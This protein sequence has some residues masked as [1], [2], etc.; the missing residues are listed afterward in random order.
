MRA[1]G[2]AAT[3]A[4][5]KP[6]YEAKMNLQRDSIDTSSR[7]FLAFC[8]YVIVVGHVTGFLIRECAPQ[9]GVHRYSE[10][11]AMAPDAERRHLATRGDPGLL[12]GLLGRWRICQ[13]SFH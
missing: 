6:G 9:P 7:L 8:P 11:P 5:L 3:R 12:G 13:R 4:T 10:E 1:H 2:I